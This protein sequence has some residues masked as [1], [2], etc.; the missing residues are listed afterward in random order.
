MGGEGGEERDVLMKKS[1]V[2]SCKRPRRDAK[3][4]S[5]QKNLVVAIPAR[6]ALF[7]STGDYVGGLF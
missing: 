6:P 4:S 2:E 5:A 1:K 7:H 3:W